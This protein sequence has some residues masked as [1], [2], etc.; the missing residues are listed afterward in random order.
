MT[1]RIPAEN[2]PERATEQL[3]GVLRFALECLCDDP[4]ERNCRTERVA[5]GHPAAACIPSVEA[6]RCEPQPDNAL[7]ALN[8]R[9]GGWRELNN[10]GATLT[11]EKVR[12]LN[13]MEERLAVVAIADDAVHGIGSHVADQ[14]ADLSATAR[15]R[16]GVA[17]FV[18]GVKIA[19]RIRNQQPMS[20]DQDSITPS[21]RGFTTNNVHRLEV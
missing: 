3:I 12:T 20:S 16:R 14:S 4:N 5:E 11:I 18:P 19:G 15:Q 17:H 1:D 2:A 21:S 7:R 10:V 13:L 8:K 9:Y 6:S